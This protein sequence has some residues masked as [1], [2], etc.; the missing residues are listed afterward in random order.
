MAGDR[1]QQ[2]DTNSNSSISKSRAPHPT[3]ILA[4]KVLALPANG[5]VS[6]AHLVEEGLVTPGNA[7]VC[8]TWPYSA[9][10]TAQGTFDARWHPL[11]RDFVSP[12]GTEF[13]RAEFETP[14]AWAT[15]VCRV[16]RAQARAQKL[17]KPSVEPQ[18]VEPPES[19]AA[20]PSARRGA[21]SKG[22]KASSRSVSFNGGSGESRVAVNGWTACRVQFPRDDPN[23]ALA[24]HLYADADTPS[25]DHATHSDAGSHSPNTQDDGAPEIIEISLDALRQELCARINRARVAKKR[26]SETQIQDSGSVPVV[27]TENG[28]ENGSESDA[29]HEPIDTQRSNLELAEISGAVEGLAKRVESDLALSCV[30]QRKAAAVAS[31]AITASA[32]NPLSPHNHEPKDGS[33]KDMHSRKRKSIP[34]MSRHSKLS[35]IPTENSD[36][37]IETDDYIDKSYSQVMKRLGPQSKA[38]LAYFQDRAQ[39]LKRLQPDPKS[40]RYQRKQHLRRSIANAMDIWL[41][42]RQMFRRQHKDYQQQQHQIMHRDQLKHSSSR[43]SSHLPS[44]CSLAS[45]SSAG[46]QSAEQPAWITKPAANSSPIC[47]MLV[48]L[49]SLQTGHGGPLRLCTQCGSTGDLLL[50]CHGCGDQYH[51]FCADMAGSVD[52]KPFLCPAC[53]VC[54]RCL[55]SLP[56]DDLAQCSDC[57][58]YM[59][60]QCSHQ[61]SEHNDGLVGAVAENG[62]WVCDS[63]A[64][65]VECGFKMTTEDALRYKS[66]DTSSS[67]TKSVSEWHT[68]VTW[69]YD[70][71]VCGHCA[72][73][74]EKAKVCP[75]CIATYA[76]CKIGTNMVCCD[77]CAFWIHTEC[78][79]SL[80]PEVYDA[81]IT[82]EDA[83]YVCPKCA[84][85][86]DACL[87][88]LDSSTSECD[89]TDPGVHPGLPRC[90]RSLVMDSTGAVAKLDTA[91]ATL[92]SQISLVTPIRSQPPESVL[93]QPVKSEPETEAA[94]MLLS[95]TQSDVRFDRF[96][97]E[98]LEMRYCVASPP[99]LSPNHPAY[100]AT[101]DWRSCALCGLRGDGLPLSKQR[102][103]L[104]R[105]VPL[106]TGSSKPRLRLVANK[107]AHVECLAWSWGPRPIATGSTSKRTSTDSMLDTLLIQFEGG[108][109]DS[110]D[111]VDLV[112]TLCKRTGASFH[113]CAPVPCFDTAYHLP[114]LLL[115]GTPSPEPPLSGQPQYCAGWRRAL[116]ADHAP[117]FSAMMPADGAV[118]STSYEN[119]RVEGYIENLSID[120]DSAD[121]DG[122]Q[123]ATR[124][125]NLVVLNWGAQSSK[126]P[127]GFCCMR[128]F[129]LGSIQHTIYVELASAW[130]GW[131]QPGVPE[132]IPNNVKCT[133]QDLSL[134]IL[135]RRLFD[136]ILVDD[137][138]GMLAEIV[139]DAAVCNP[140]RFLGISRA[141]TDW[142]FDQRPSAMP[143]PSS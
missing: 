129:E 142:S 69:A 73:Q 53:R 80:T 19:G 134:S 77:V 51:S 108:L 35:R 111:Q 38:C 21:R 81:L 126:Q 84:R 124:I 141:C 104:G 97:M 127:T 130:R 47:S 41:Y 100:A 56:A 37:D 48:P 66:P 36:S 40:L 29:N 63:C 133:A 15:A 60:A 136:Q 2:K 86:D 99:R 46:T 3:S 64:V 44:A 120:H 39:T 139:V 135:L 122:E 30:Q 23:R 75:E 1:R 52:D 113:C 45:S 87:V 34:D 18:A 26:Q 7:V 138:R 98:A 27:L 32:G 16:V 115:A 102:P 83:P 55:D 116:C 117:M 14:S 101:Q 22:S 90:L 85:S 58:L 74:I 132:K 67:D 114:C 54:T 25:S 78:D 72:Q 17:G 123:M 4:T 106:V 110:K 88:E 24:L 94:N 89:D 9:V 76:N 125:G 33:R 11:P 59:H 50:A 57:G 128:V 10:V 49:E 13:M 6:V 119:V 61:R 140:Y 96:A 118:E 43:R 131:I 20:N 82:L 68:R 112:C 8:N 28:D 105:L 79:P 143:H 65:C 107:W 93:T 62:R 92:A 42:Q 109:L 70:F 5:K 31:D 71:S 103:S 121:T 137:K 91:M 12:Y 95:L